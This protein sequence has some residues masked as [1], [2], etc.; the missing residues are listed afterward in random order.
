MSWL[1]KPSSSPHIIDGMINSKQHKVFSQD[2]NLSGSKPIMRSENQDDGLE[3]TWSVWVYINDITYNEIDIV[4]F[5]I[6]EIMYV[7]A[8]T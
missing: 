6:K 7:L 8:I 5:S 1:L 4:I 2:P 3:F